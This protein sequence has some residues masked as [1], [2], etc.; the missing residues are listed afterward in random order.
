MSPKPKYGQNNEKLPK[1]LQDCLK[2]LIDK[3]EKEDAW[4]RKQQ[5]KL[6]KKNDEFWHGIQ[7][8][9]W[10]ESRQDWIS[11]TDT[12]WYQEEEGRE[13]AEGP[14]YDFVAN[15]YRAH[16]E[17]IIA[18]LS[19]NIP[20][21][22]FPPDDA[23]DDEDITTSQVYAKIA[24]LI[25]RHNKF[26]ILFLR[27]LFLLWNQGIVCAY[28]APRADK[29]FG[30]INIPNYKESL[31]CMNCEMEKPIGED[32][33]FDGMPCPTCGQPM[34]MV[35][36]LDDFQ[37]SPKSRVMIEC[38]GPLFVKVSYYSRTQKDTP[39]LS[40]NTDRPR[41][42]LKHLYPHIA[43]DLRKDE[44]E[45]GMYEKLA[46]T[47]SSYSSY[48]TIDENR[49]LLTLKQ[50][51]LRPW[52][53]EG[54]PPEKKEEQKQLQKLFPNGAYVAYVGT[55]YAESRDEDLDK[56]WTIGQA[57][58]S[59]Y[60]HSDP[61]GQPLIPIQEIT[62]VHLNLTE[63]T[64]EHGIPSTFADPGVLNFEVYSRHEA[65]PG[66]V[67][68]ARPRTGQRLADAFY[69]GNRATLSRELAGFSK[70]LEQMGQFVTGS[71][72]SIYGGA[73]EG[74]SRT[75]AEYNMSRQMAL[76]RLSICWSFVVDWVA[77]M[78][79]KCV[80][81]FVEN[82]IEDE[83]YV[84]KEASGNYVNVWIRRAETTGKVGEVESEGSESFP[85]SLPQKQALLMKL[86]EMN[87]EF[88]NTAL[89]SPENRRLL[90]DYLSNPDFKIPGEVQR[91]LQMVEINE[92]RKGN[93]IPVD[94]LVDDHSIHAETLRNYLADSPGQEIKRTQPK[95]YALMQQ[96]LQGHLQG[97]KPP[98]TA[99]PKPQQPK[100]NGAPGALPPTPPDEQTIP[101][102]VA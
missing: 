36:V 55:T 67:F 60:I 91:S 89:Y 32:E 21:V 11:P 64:I 80:H 63:E 100:P 29:A 97:L 84:V 54:L 10:S 38:Y 56:Y 58:L 50:W 14:F 28:H 65:R 26:K 77:R 88:L 83:R 71:F 59:Q 93:N 66:F 69:E 46:R 7:F 23:D 62:N 33:A 43:D 95:V 2:E 25:M 9:F 13:E 68:P 47:P 34:K 52:A 53:F 78:L 75:A 17:A 94:N 61:L 16:G 51:W 85:L 3:Y 30:E 92:M 45:Q 48:N 86:M 49:N 76:Q 70:Q 101:G 102:K 87:N 39:Y 41:E 40:L 18:A 31:T 19:A 5:I 73:A 37:K 81:L 20:A 99:G 74:K 72:P 8:I 6:W 82:M 90:A 15:I 44:G 27:S 79:E 35:P 4:I 96:H 1:E 98:P 12:R 42:F 57:G 24:D 22:R